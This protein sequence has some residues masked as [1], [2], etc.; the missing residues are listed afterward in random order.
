V[1]I[2]R[3]ITKECQMEQQ[4]IQSQKMEAI[5]TLAGGIAHDFNNILAAINGFAELTL[6]EAEENTSVHKNLS[7]ILRAGLRA[8]KLVQQILTFSRQ[9]IPECIP[10][11]VKHVVE[12]AAKL[13]R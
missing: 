2:I 11:R 7:E 1:A 12:E 8:A 5:G 9:T 4:L 10:I 13:L 6:C 3:D